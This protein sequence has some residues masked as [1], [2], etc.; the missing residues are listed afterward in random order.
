MFGG[1][2]IQILKIT[3]KIFKKYFNMFLNKILF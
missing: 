2:N 1:F 3:F